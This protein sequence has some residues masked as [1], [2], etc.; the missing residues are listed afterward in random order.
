MSPR[1]LSPDSQALIGLLCGAVLLGVVL[2]LE[3]YCVQQ[4]RVTFEQL[5]R[6]QERRLTLETISEAILG[7]ETGQR[8]YLL[9]SRGEYIEP[10]IAGQVQLAA[11]LPVLQRLLAE[12]GDSGQLEN[13]RA[14]ERLLDTRRKQMDQVLD[15]QRAQGLDAAL[16]FV[17]TNQ[18]HFVMDAIRQ[19]LDR[20]SAVEL[21]Q[22]DARMASSQTSLGRNLAFST[23]LS[24]MAIALMVVILLLVRRE[25]ARRVEAARQLDAAN[26]SLELRVR[27]ATEGL[28][29]A[30]AVLEAEVRQRRAAEAELQREHELLDARVTERTAELVEAGESKSRFFSAASHDLRQ[31]LHSLTLLNA[32]LRSQ[33]LAQPV[34]DIVEAQQQMIDSMGRMIHALLNISM[35]ESGVVRPQIRDFPLQEIMAPLRA[36]FAPLADARGLSLEFATDSPVVKSDPTLLKEVLQNLVGNA[37]RYTERGGVRVGV[38]RTADRVLIEVRDSGPGIPV[39]DLDLVFEPFHQLRSQGRPREGFGLGLAV[40]RQLVKV[41]GIELK[42]ESTVGVGTSFTIEVT[43]GRESKP[44]GVR[45]AVAGGVPRRGGGILLVDDEA[46]VLQATAIFLRVEGHEV[47]TAGSPDEALAKLG[48]LDRAP[49]L[50]VSD[51]QLGLPVTGA[52]L[53]ER[54]RATVGRDIP[55]VVL[56]GDMLRVVRRCEHLAN[57]RVF[58]K[59]VDAEELAQHLRA[60]LEA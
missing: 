10:Y 14:L 49:D 24:I 56:S 29:A 60:T 45:A 9:T 53:I 22:V 35:L 11:R 57:C 20:M 50:I 5:Q 44:A 28:S 13:F 1:R 59:P 38:E 15:L 31:P 6:T 37:V 36:E 32:T 52:E 41:L 21:R 58:H 54:V 25:F 34:R 46:T 7:M 8:G 4:V 26:A 30:N 12:D 47:I 19:L 42:V 48:R 33:P 55:A 51:F 17:T 39:A 43:P 23:L 3:Y 16:A 2:A 40:V 27:D 18:G